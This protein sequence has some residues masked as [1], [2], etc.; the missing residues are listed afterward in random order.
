ML[1]NLMIPSETLHEDPPPALS[2]FVSIMGFQHDPALKN[3][4][5]LANRALLFLIHGAFSHLSLK[6][7]HPILIIVLVVIWIRNIEDSFP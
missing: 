1:V 3:Q 4:A 7:P 5:K 2:G 6:K